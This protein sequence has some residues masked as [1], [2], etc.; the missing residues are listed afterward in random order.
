MPASN[1]IIEGAYLQDIL[2]QP[3][4]I[5]DTVTVLAKSEKLNDFIGNLLPSS[6]EQIVFTGMGGSYQ[7]LYPLYLTLVEL[8]YPARMAETSELLRFMPSLLTSRTLLIV[9]SQSG[10][11]GEILRL[12]K[13]GADR[14]TILAITNDASAPLAKEADVIALIQ[15]GPE[16]SGACKTATAT[17]AALTWIGGA[18]SKRAVSATDNLIQQAAQAVEQYLAHWRDHV[19]LLVPELDGIRHLFI[20]GR[21]TSLPAAGI[22]G[23]LMKE[24]AHFQ[25]EGMGSAAFRH[26]PFEMLNKECFVLVFAG[27]AV[28]ES[29]NR[30]LV[31]DVRR[32]GAK[33]ELIASDA[34]IRAFRLPEVEREVRPIVEMLPLQM[35]SLA[36]AAL[37]GREAGKFERIEKVTTEE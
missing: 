5:R 7:V 10:R 37:T 28:V 8:G 36:L 25:A 4:A 13:H 26:G 35:V 27:D 20:T 24:T 22:G 23:M 33:A 19:A 1:T 16:A 12:L 31:N 6:Y 14:P 29:L 30:S 3:R 11:S 32:T 21:G 18:L 15:A 9:A 17:L 34:D 2:D